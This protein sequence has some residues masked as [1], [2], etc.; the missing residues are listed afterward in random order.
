MSNKELKRVLQEIKD[1]CH[2]ADC[3]ENCKYYINDKCILADIPDEWSIDEIGKNDGDKWHKLYSWLV[4]LRFASTPNARQ[5]LKDF[6]IK[7][8][9]A[10]LIDNII[11]YMNQLDE[12]EDDE[13]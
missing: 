9:M 3:E 12:E 8:A 11:E 4:D 2:Y 13:A 6:T 7:K 5:G 10:D 1:Y